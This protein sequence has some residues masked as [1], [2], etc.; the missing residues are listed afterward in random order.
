[1]DSAL[2]P[3]DIQARIRAGA[4]VD[5]VA[6]AAGVPV[7]SLD[8]FAAPVLAE[9]DHVAG[10]AQTHPVRR[11][12]ETTSHRTLRQTVRETLAPR[13]LNDKAVQWDAWKIE[14]RRWQI[15]AVLGEGGD[16]REGLFLYDLTGRFSAVDLVKAGAAAVG[17]KGGG[18][19]PDMAQ[20]GGPDGANANDALVAI[21]QAMVVPA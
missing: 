8:A 1:M 4:T 9:R 19:R 13:G 5:D 2:R 16:R 17:G 10:L 6:R 14:G 12:G 18:G 7:E 3:R 11:R 21:E 20:A 15:Q